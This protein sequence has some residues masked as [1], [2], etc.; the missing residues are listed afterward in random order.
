MFDN[1]IS[2]E[3]MIRIT[4]FK[5]QQPKTK[6]SY[7]LHKQFNELETHVMALQWRS[8]NFVSGGG[9]IQLNIILKNYKY[10]L[11]N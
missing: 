8:Q 9:K 2:L 5:N 11:K 3:V 4:S 6:K 10:V 1:S 7:P